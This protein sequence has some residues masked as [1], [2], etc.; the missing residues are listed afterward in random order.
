MGGRRWIVLCACLGASACGRDLT[1][2]HNGRAVP[3]ADAGPS[4][5]DAS[6]P[7][8][9][10]E[11]LD[12][13]GDTITDVEEGTGDLDFDGIP[14]FLDLDSA[15]DGVRDAFEAGD[16]DL[17]TP[18][19]ECVKEV[20]AAVPSVER[21]D[22]AADFEDPDSDNDGF[23]D[24]E[25]RAFGLDPCNP[26][27]DGDG[28][29]DLI[30]GA[31]ARVSCPDGHTG[32]YCDCG[33]DPSCG[34]PAGDYYV[35][36][37][38]RGAAR[39]RDLWFDT[40][41]RAADVF[42]LADTSASMA[43]TL[44]NVQR[45]VASARD[46]LID[47]LSVSIP[48]VWIGGGQQEDLPLGAY[49]DAPAEPLRLA[50]GMTAPERRSE[51]AT[52]LGA[53]TIHE[54]G[55]TPEAQTEA[56][57]QLVTGEGGHWAHTSGESYVLP[58]LAAACIAGG[59]GA[60][61]FRQSALPIIVHF[62]D[63]CSHAG[64]PGEDPACT[65]YEG[66]DPAPHSWSD[67]VRVLERRG[68]KYI[69]V[70]ARDRAPGEPGCADVNGPRGDLPCYFMRR[71]AEATHTVDLDGTPL[72]YDLPSAADAS[73]LVATV[74]RAIDTVVTSVPFDVD[75]AVRDDPTDPTRVDATRF[76]VRRGPACR[77][78]I[79]PT[80]P[81]FTGAPG[82]EQP[83]AALDDSSFFGVLPG[84]RLLFRLTF[85]NDFRRG[86]PTAQIFVAFVDVRA[87][88]A[89]ALDTRRVLVVVPAAPLL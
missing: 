28:T 89:P 52:A 68:A 73:E 3:A 20:D 7:P 10:V 35:T 23:G 46:G 41:V 49:G 16:A 43:G 59:S 60:P 58:P 63:A 6:R 66:V 75:T 64:P 33:R 25:E 81:C 76:V 79:H 87:D 14:N 39:E 11:A 26:D 50:I 45:T 84:T 51:V 54:G 85:R 27:S 1:L 9:P 55:D 32:L 80:V 4:G 47:R 65:A 24:G 70:N 62:T 61:C 18:A 40:T 5:G 17:R 88:G 36:L 19:R 34:V 71:T 13:D 44:A 30:E 21:P 78:A 37:P 67:M 74:V 29:D 86:G 57:Y 72:V 69:G 8:P 83:V 53:M 48:D 15:T 77:A 31:L 42:L 12:S 2:A 82:S 56:L 38:Y 22:G